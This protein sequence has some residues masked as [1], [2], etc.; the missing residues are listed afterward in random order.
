MGGISAHITDRRGDVRRTSNDIVLGDDFKS[1]RGLLD[2]DPS[3]ACQTAVFG[4]FDW[5]I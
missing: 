1:S 3:L 5:C 4:Q 2:H